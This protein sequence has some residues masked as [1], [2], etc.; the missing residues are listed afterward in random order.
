MKQ[1]FDRCF[2]KP[3]VQSWLSVGVEFPSIWL[4]T[5]AEVLR[6]HS[7]RSYVFQVPGP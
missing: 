7:S 1:I 3:L 4:N 5:L 6:E 2:K